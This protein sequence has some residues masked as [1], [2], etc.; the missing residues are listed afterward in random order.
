MSAG[1]ALRVRR[2]VGVTRGVVLVLHG[3]KAESRA[4]ARP[5]HLSAVRMRFFA[6][7]VH[8]AERR[9]GIAV[10]SLRY[11]WRGWNGAEASPVADARWALDRIRAEHGA[12]PVV[13]IGHSMG[14]RTALRVVDDAGVCA[15]L[16]LAP[17]LP[18]GE[19]R[20]P[21]G[22]RP[23]LVMHG[24]ADRWTDPVASRAY[25]VAAAAEGTP[26]RWVPIPDVGHFLLRERRLWRRLALDF[27]AGLP[28]LHGQAEAAA[29]PNPEQ[30][31]DPGDPHSDDRCT[32]R[33]RP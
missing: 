32:G 20:L 2:A 10:W 26:A 31:A 33:S 17:W 3:G 13:L 12:V 28:C 6:R 18:D 30:Q 1:P 21:L 8:R 29:A 25:V 15:V 23:L 11:R 5:W 4:P 24:T 16:G 27:V 22:P 19:P 9:H 14:G 7:A